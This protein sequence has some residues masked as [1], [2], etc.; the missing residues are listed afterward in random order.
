MQILLANHVEKKGNDMYKVAGAQLRK[1]LKKI[2][3]GLKPLLRAAIK[4][5]LRFNKIID[6]MIDGASPREESLQ[7]ERARSAQQEFVLDQVN[8]LKAA[9]AHDVENPES[10][11]RAANPFEH[12]VAAKDDEEED[13]SDAADGDSDSESDSD[14]SSGGPKK[15][16]NTGDLSDDE[17]DG[18][19]DRDSDDDAE[20]SDNEKDEEEEPN[21][22]VTS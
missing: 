16:S 22:F 10:Q 17:S 18:D 7:L 1:D 14:A 3:I 12:E 11:L 9:W 2:S 21:L 19:S 6:Q 8:F 15:S 5:L 20:N 4:E 13:E